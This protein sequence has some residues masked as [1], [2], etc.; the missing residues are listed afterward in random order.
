[1]NSEEYEGGFERVDVDSILSSIESNFHAW[2][3][4]FVVLAVGHGD[5]AAVEQLRASFKRMRPDIA[6]ALGKTIFLGDMRHVLD[7]VEVPSTIVQVSD[8]FAVPVSVGRYIQSK[9][10]GKASLEI[11]KSDGH[12]PQ[13]V[14]AQQLLEILDRVLLITQE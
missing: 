14:A 5:A 10:K 13:L 11:I 12:F 4:S 1:M 6:L 8:D 7:K 9:M 2:A 3:D